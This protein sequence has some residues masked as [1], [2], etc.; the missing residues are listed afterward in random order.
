MKKL[1]LVFVVCILFTV[2]S[3]AETIVVDPNESGDFTNIQDAINSSWPG[4]TVIVRPGIYYGVEGHIYFNFSPIRLTSTNP[5]DPNIVEATVIDASMHF[6]SGEGPDSILTGFTLGYITGAADAS[7][8]ITNNI[9]T[10][11]TDCDGLISQNTIIG[12]LQSCD[13]TVSDNYFSSG[14]GRCAFR[15]NANFY[16][17]RIVG[18]TVYAGISSDAFGLFDECTGIIQNNFIS[19]NGAFTTNSRFLS[20]IIADCDG[21]VIVNNTVVNNRGFFIHPSSHNIVAKNNIFANNENVNYF[22]VR[23]YN[24]FW[25]SGGNFVAQGTGNVIRDPLFINEGYWDNNGTTEDI[26]DD[27]WVDGDYHLKSEIGRWDP[28]A[29]AWVLDV[30]T[31]RCIDSGDPCDSI[32]VEPNPNGGRINMGAYGGTAEASKSPSGI[33]KPVCSVKLEGD[34]NGD[35]KVDFADFTLVVNNWLECNLDPPEACWQ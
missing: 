11:I 7:P 1:I 20:A 27:T 9:I 33:V 5:I 10:Q 25:P 34:V 12:I 24:C 23:S 22:S 2:P 29:E 35:C 15:C 4:D 28:D 18:R 32:G 30:T 21:I 3:I 6:D 16:H 14:G 31:S 26:S 19:G 8:T 17:N 13:G